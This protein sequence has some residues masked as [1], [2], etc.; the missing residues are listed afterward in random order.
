[1]GQWLRENNLMPDYVVSSPAERAKQTTL[2]VCKE[3]GIDKKTIHSDPRIY[4]ADVTGLMQVLADCPA[5]ARNV[6]LVGH[7][8]GLESLLDYLCGDNTPLSE[9]GKL[10]PTATVAQLQIPETWDN[11][12]AGVATLVSIT[13][14][15]SLT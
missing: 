10:L 2:K 11:L 3:L 13:R 7:N 12:H 4:D 5:A 14:P 15:A 9:D 1:M 8:P 6:L